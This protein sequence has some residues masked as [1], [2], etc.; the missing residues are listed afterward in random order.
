[1]DDNQITE[2]LDTFRSINGFTQEILGN[3][4]RVI[5]GQDGVKKLVLISILSGGH[6]I[7]TGVPGLAKT[8]LVKNLARLLD[9]SFSRIQFTP[10]LMPSDIIGAEIV[11]IGDD[12]RKSFRFVKGPVFANLLL[13]DEIN[14]TPPKTQAALLQAMEEKV[15][16]SGGQNYELPKPFFVFATQNPIEQEGTYPLP[17][18]ELDRF[19]FNIEIDYPGSSDEFEIAK[20]FPDMEKGA[21]GPIIGHEKLGVFLDFIP[22]VKISDELIRDIVGIVKNTRPSET[23]KDIVKKYILW[24][25]GPRA[26]QYLM[27]ASKANALLKGH[28]VVS[29]EDVRELL[30]PVLKH[31]IILNFAAQAEGVTKEDII[32]AL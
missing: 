4:G 24:G 1:M 14:R 20:R 5:I 23:R 19:L 6:S 30:V 25:A 32:N 7:I 17:E 11:D 21:P 28:T 29:D 18:A 8:M 26:S 10:D 31:R 13:A 27:H 16:T 9:I 3:I 22:K 15:V 12:K 2:D